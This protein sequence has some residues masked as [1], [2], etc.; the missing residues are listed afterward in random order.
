MPTLARGIEPALYQ[1]DLL[2]R[3]SDGYVARGVSAWVLVTPASRFAQDSTAFA[4][5]L[6]LTK[7]WEAQ[8]DVETIVALQ[9]AYL[10]H[11]ANEL[12]SRP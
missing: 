8:I 6:S 1:L 9:R 7:S 2:Q 10:E 4:E 12:R 11:L 3:S 5:A